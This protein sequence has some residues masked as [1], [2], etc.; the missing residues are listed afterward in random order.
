MVIEL[1]NTIKT[2]SSRYK[3]Y[4]FPKCLGKCTTDTFRTLHCK[5]I[6]RGKTVSSAELVKTVRHPN[7]AIPKA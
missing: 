6:L 2:F 1:I 7:R 4:D 5:A 3:T